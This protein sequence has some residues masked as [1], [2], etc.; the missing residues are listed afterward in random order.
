NLLERELHTLTKNIESNFPL[1]FRL[2]RSNAIPREEKQVS[3]IL[4][5]DPS[6]FPN[7]VLR[8][9]VDPSLMPI[10]NETWRSNFYLALII[11]VIPLLAGFL[12][13]IEVGLRRE[14]EDAKNKVDFVANI[15]HELKTPLTSIRMFIEMLLLGRTRSVKENRESLTIILKESERLGRLID[16]LLG[17][18]T[19][20]RNKR[21][22]QRR[23]E[24]MA[25]I[26]RD[27]VKP[28]RSDDRGSDRQIKLA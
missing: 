13:F 15:S 3:F 20:E 8:A 6:L 1:R 27:T 17:F 25:R 14:I 11:I 24:A 18:N 9:T 22:F 10:N 12:W 23:P 4:P 2:Q 21:V 19:L 16:R 26:V 7:W 5:V 28:F